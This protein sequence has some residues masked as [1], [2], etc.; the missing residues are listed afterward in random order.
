ML[1]HRRERRHRNQLE[2]ALTEKDAIIKSISKKEEK[3]VAE[4]QVCKR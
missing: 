3:L 4:I 2:A 1:F